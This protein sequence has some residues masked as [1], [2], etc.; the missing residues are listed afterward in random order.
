MFL[1]VWP[2]FGQG[3]VWVAPLRPSLSVASA[4]M[5]WRTERWRGFFLTVP[6]GVSQ[7]GLEG[8]RWP[9]SHC[10]GISNLVWHLQGGQLP[11]VKTGAAGL[12]R[13]RLGILRMSLLHSI[14]Q[15]K[16][17]AKSHERG[18]ETCHFLMGKGAFAN[19][20]WRHCWQPPSGTMNHSSQG[21]FW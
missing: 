4:G 3:S 5:A 21:L 19:R 13:S 15:S 10:L 6:P 8:Q 9:H 1:W 12:Q 2:E 7:V 18:G 20:H 16:S 14:N 11:R 17:Q